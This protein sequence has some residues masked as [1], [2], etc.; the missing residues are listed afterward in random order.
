MATTFTARAGS[1]FRA[2]IEY[3]EPPIPPATNP[4]SGELI[5]TT[6]FTAR[7]QLRSSSGNRRVILSVSESSDPSSIL[8][9][10]P[11]TTAG[12]RWLIF[13]PASITRS[14]PP[15]SH[16]E[17]ELVSDANADDVTALFSGAF[18]ISPEQVV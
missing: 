18:R 4:K 17:M 14:L 9:L 2:N 11:A 3:R 12:G 13:F 6:G 16:L 1:S 5:D 15:V 8:S 10:D 7:L